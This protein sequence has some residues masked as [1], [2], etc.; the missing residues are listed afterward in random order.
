MGIFSGIDSTVLATRLAE[1]QAAYLDLLAGEQAVSVRAADGKTVTFTPAD[2]DSLRRHILELQNAL[3]IGGE[4]VPGWN[5]IGGK[6]L[7]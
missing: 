4:K 7:R 2:R 5:I 3:G 6:G 1:A